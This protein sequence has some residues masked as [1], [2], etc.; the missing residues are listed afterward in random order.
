M[1][2]TVPI[3]N[4][5]YKNKREDPLSSISCYYPNLYCIRCTVQ[6]TRARIFTSQNRNSIIH[7]MLISMMHVYQWPWFASLIAIGLL[8]L[9][10]A[11][12]DNSS[13][14]NNDQR[15]DAVKQAFQHAWAGYSKYAYG[16]DEILSVSNGTSDTRNGWGASI[17]DGLDT[18]IIMG[19]EDDYQ[20]ALEHVQNVD[21][22]SSKNLSK[23][24]ETNIRY[25]GGL[26]SAY[27]L[28]PDPILLQKAIDLTN[29]VILP[30]YDTP[31]GIPAA[32]VNTSSGQPIIENQLTL[33]EF[34]SMQLELVRLSQITGDPYYERIANSVLD[35]MARVPSRIPGLY[36]MSWDLLTF[37]PTSSYITIAGGADSCYEYFLKTHLLM[38][39]TENTQLG[40]WVTATDS[41]H[42]YLRS[43]TKEGLVFLGEFSGNYKLLQTGELVCFMPGNIL[44]GARYLNDSKLETFAQEL[45]D[46]CY[47]AWIR[48]P[49]GLAPETWSWTDKTQ[50]MTYYP[51]NMHR[52][53][54][55]Y[56]FV[57]QNMTFDLRPETV[58]S[59]FYFYRLTGDSSYQDKAWKIFEAI[60]KYCKTASGYTR[61]S[62]VMTPDDV[63]PLDFQESYFFAET[64]KYLYLIFSDPQQ[65]SLDE[66]VFNTEAHP[67]KLR[68]PLKVQFPFASSNR[69]DEQHV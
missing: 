48:T 21:W 62:N 64:L 55:T 2:V 52:I 47:E 66:Y 30:A 28:R 20:K 50:N 46:S 49:T 35:K 36:P 69:T 11:A 42:N 44:L 34:G 6:L 9:V 43:E 14:T 5:T 13:P 57:P 18:M 54:D 1:N 15:K 60:E 41:M 31:G 16:H 22:R 23:T 10:K 65:I 38:Q 32:Y 68:S 26:L 12:D 29:Q 37:K 25:V 40:M 51:E 61:I 53:I 19:L 58:E 17:F 56:G 67:F 63:Q 39:G 8:R 24:F 7:Y 59:L 33:A 4:V 3:K 27:D 45:M